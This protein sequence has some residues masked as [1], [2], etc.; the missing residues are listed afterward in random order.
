MTPLEI[1]QELGYSEL[2]SVLS[3]VIHQPVPA[4]T[5]VNL[6]ARFH[7][8]IRT[9]LG[10]RVDSEHIY[11]P[12]LEVLTELEVPRMC[13]PVKSAGNF[14]AV[15]FPGC[16]LHRSSLTLARVIFTAWTVAS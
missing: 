5:L 14:P 16:L 7:A 13:F 2:Y 3:P 12:E 1:A 8:I 11:L 9:E 4:T 6:Q 10:D 15:S